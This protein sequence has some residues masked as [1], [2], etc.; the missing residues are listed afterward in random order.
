MD[1]ALKRT[2]DGLSGGESN[3]AAAGNSDGFIGVSSRDAGGACGSCARRQEGADS[4]ETGGARGGFGRG[5]ARGRRRWRAAANG[6]REGENRGK[7]EREM[8]VN[9]NS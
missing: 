3:S 5:A 8:E 1:F 9:A 6:V 4:S 7:R 2:G